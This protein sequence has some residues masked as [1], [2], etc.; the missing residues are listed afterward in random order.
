VPASHNPAPSSSIIITPWS[1]THN[2]VPPVPGVERVNGVQHGLAD[3]YVAWPYPLRAPIC[4]RTNADFMSIPLAHLFG[5]QQHV[6]GCRVIRLS[7]ATH[8]AKFVLLLMNA[9]T[10]HTHLGF[11]SLAQTLS[12]IRIKK[13][14]SVS[15]IIVR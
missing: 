6:G 5:R 9:R 2:Q 13:A 14:A 8:Q 3:F 7:P 10:H 11:C 12:A 4:E 1:I 15:E